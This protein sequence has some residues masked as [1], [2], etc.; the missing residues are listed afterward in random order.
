MPSSNSAPSELTPSQGA[1]L[2]ALARRTLMEQFD[3]PIPEERAQHLEDLL[4]DPAL[5]THCGTFVTLKIDA[6]LRG[7]IGSLTGSEPLAE[8]VRT[9]AVNAAFYDPRFQAVTDQELDKIRIE[10]S[11]LTE[12]KPISYSDESD[13]LAQLRPRV[14]GV[15]I[16]KGVKSATFLPQVWKQ[17]PIPES[18]LSNLCMKAGL[19][20]D[21]WREGELVVE[22][23][24]VQYF[25]ETL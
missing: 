5:Q 16:R 18:F 14:D 25:E 12:P 19:A 2:V 7:C 8:G 4:N 11:V 3:R 10:V 6:N 13:L 15:T 1:A 24:Q 23:Y 22:T 17:L 21:A 9:H 20:S